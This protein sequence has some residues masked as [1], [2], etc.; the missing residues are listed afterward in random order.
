MHVSGF[1]FEGS[2]LWGSS[3]G[4]YGS[5]LRVLAVW[6]SGFK[7]LRFRALSH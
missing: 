5:G 2:G 6:G 7:A 1:R 3:V 4:V